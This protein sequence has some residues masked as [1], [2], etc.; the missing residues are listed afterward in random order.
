MMESSSLS[1][2][3][4]SSLTFPLSHQS[5]PNVCTLLSDT[6]FS[7]TVYSVESLPA[8][9]RDYFNMLVV[10]DYDTLIPSR[11]LE[12]IWDKD[13]IETENSMCGEFTL[14]SLYS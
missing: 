9:L 3:L 12:A 7:Y 11:A 10:F 14:I 1:L 5:K 2:S 4:T 13:D 8:N 6:S